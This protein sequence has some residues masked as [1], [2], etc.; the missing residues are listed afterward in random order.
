MQFSCACGECVRD[1][2]DSLP[3]KA[4]LLPDESY[5]DCFTS[6]CKRVDSYVAAMLAG[7]GKEWLEQH[8]NEG[9]AKLNLTTYQVVRDLFGDLF[10]EYTRHVF[11][12]PSCGRLY[13]TDPRN[14]MNLVPFSPASEPPRVDILTRNV[15]ETPEKGVG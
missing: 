3:H 1:Q 10:F 15:E 14:Y 12:C 6:L 5:F 2:S 9:Y 7:R 4:Y 8:Y 13:V 11:V